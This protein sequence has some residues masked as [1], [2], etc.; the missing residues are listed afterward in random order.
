MKSHFLCL[1]CIASLAVL[2]VSGGARADDKTAEPKAEEAA[3]PSRPT[4]SSSTS[5]SSSSTTTKPTARA[6]PYAAYLK[7][8]QERKGLFNMWYKGNKLYAE[9]N[10]SH[11][12][13]EYLVLI[14]IA[15]G[16]G[17]FPLVA[18]YTWQLSEDDWLWKFRKVD[19]RVLVIR[20]NVRFR[21]NRGYPEQTAVERAYTDS[22]LF[23]LRIVSKGPRGG[24]LVDFSPVFMSDLPQI[25]QVLPGFGFST[26]KS[27][28]ASVKAF[29]RNVELEVAATYA[30]SGRYVFDTVADSRGVTINVHYSISALPSSSYKPRVADDRVGYFLTVIKNFNK[31]SD[32]DQFERY[33]N[34]WNLRKPP[35]A[36]TAPY[37]PKDQIVFWIEKTVPHKYRKAVRD[38]ISEWN[39]AFEKA[40]WL[41]AIE[42]RQQPDDAD[43]DP[44]DVNYNTFRWITSSSSFAMGPTRVNPKTGEILDAD[45]IFDADFLQ[46]WKEEFETLTP[47]DVAAMTGGPLEPVEAKEQEQPS[48]SDILLQSRRMRPACRLSHGMSRQLAFGAAAI[49]ALSVRRDAKEA[50]V[51]KEKLIMQGLKET[52]MHEVGH[53]LGLRHNFKASKMMDLKEINN[54]DKK[55]RA[56]VASVMDYNPTNIVPSE[57]HQ[58]DYYTPTIGPYDYWAIEYGYK[59][60]PGGSAEVKALRKIASRSG[61]A[62]LNYATDYDTYA[63][64]PDPDANLYDLGNDALQYA[65]ARAQIVKEVVPGLIDRTTEEGEDY[66]QA[67]RAFNILLSEHG[68]AMFFAARLIG[69]LHT[70]RSHKGDKD[71]KPPVEVVS[72]E[73]QRESLALLEEQVFSDTP[74]QFPSELYNYLAKSNWRHWGQVQ[75]ASRKD[76][77]VHDVISM[78]QTR[79]MSQLLS[80]T[81]LRRMH[82]TEF[83]TPPDE[84]VLTTAELI[85]RLTKAIF[86]ELDSIDEG[87]FTNRKPAISSLRRN[88]Q[89][90]YLRTM[91]RLAMGNTFAPDDCQTIAY[92]EL[93][94]LEDRI[95]QLLKSNVK[96]DSYSR[97]HLQ[98]T[99]SRI[100]KVLNAE[101]SLY[102]P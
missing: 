32:R 62:A 4:T 38:G 71:A 66:T 80:S 23:S 91:S 10:S 26:T 79:V 58:G 52:V 82:D 76:Y 5:S 30:S 54:K 31:E 14:S 48:I 69:G 35:G 63:M 93:S 49:G 33:I 2:I 56:F 70:S 86:S 41:E 96:L 98:E 94:A 37:T 16:I 29:P 99:A 90:E 28:W 92:A 36:K 39:K 25:S 68:Q 27:S 88:L 40:G 83:K 42:V 50:A 78:W 43:W 77:P 101:L 67:R 73:K 7:D 19:D 85:E 45:I 47:A 9:L 18:G 57:W 61:E 22:V 89:R 81:T 60:L 100:D 15:R 3:T 13:K 75:I 59:P 72:V 87:D 1:L 21:A 24:D 12:S 53:T 17:Q 84:D 20:R 55:D 97:A 51:E 65:K 11:Y 8:A 46:F 74:F 102:S 95:G 44:A 6:A 64:D 34:R